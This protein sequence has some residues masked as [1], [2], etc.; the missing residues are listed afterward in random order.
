MSITIGQLTE[1]FTIGSI[2]YGIVPKEVIGFEL[3]VIF[4]NEKVLIGLSPLDGEWTFSR[5][6]IS[7]LKKLFPEDVIYLEIFLELCAKSEH[8]FEKCGN[9]SIWR[10]EKIVEVI[11]NF[12]SEINKIDEVELK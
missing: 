1:V 2:K 5:N 10:G 9:F 7:S 3:F 11:Q 8:F 12:S 6:K 4:V